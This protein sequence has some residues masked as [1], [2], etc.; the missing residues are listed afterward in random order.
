MFIIFEMD[1]KAIAILLVF[2]SSASCVLW[3]PRA[4]TFPCK[5]S[6]G[7]D[8]TKSDC[9][10]TTDCV[11]RVTSKQE[12]VA[13][14]LT[15]GDGQ[16]GKSVEVIT[17]NGTS[18]NNTCSLPEMS[19]FKAEHSQSGLTA[20]GSASGGT[21]NGDPF[22]CIKFGNNG[23]WVTHTKNLLY[24]RASHSSWITPYYGDILLIGGR[25]N[26][27]TTEV[28]LQNG[29]SIRAFDLKYDTW[30]ACLIGFPDMFILTGGSH[31]SRN[32]ATVSK[33]DISGWME[34][35]PDMNKGR[36]DHGCGFF[37]TD[38]GTVL[39]VAGG[40]NNDDFAYLSS[41][42][43]HRIGSSIWHDQQP[44]PSVRAGLRGISLPDTVLMIGGYTPNSDDDIDEVLRF[45]L[46]NRFD[47][48]TSQWKR[49]GN[50]QVG[51]NRPGASLV[52]MAEVMMFCNSGAEM[53][54][55]EAFP[56]VFMFI[57]FMCF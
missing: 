27:T 21:F 17:T 5:K 55:L 45:D 26:W 32:S 51:R 2:I 28:V 9:G 7:C 54:A 3:Q 44:L 49:I 12:E 29:T 43:T 1:I 31:H 56:F 34:D 16:F 47:T 18:V 15:G 25:N 8:D 48:K 4:E 33:Y 38:M 14:L 23:S 20:C 30:D 13:I 50:L 53:I 40:F 35:L 57:F 10:G 19:Q 36:H 52:N 6:S 37:Y 42:E 11:N 22:S 39:L 46:E 24:P 41:T